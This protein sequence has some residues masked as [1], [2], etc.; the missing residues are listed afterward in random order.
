MVSKIFKYSFIKYTLRELEVQLKKKN[1]KK[2]VGW[3]SN[4][5]KKY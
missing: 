2:L 3:T 4:A 5:C 1:E